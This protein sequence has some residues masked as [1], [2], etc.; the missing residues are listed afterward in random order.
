MGFYWQQAG[1]TYLQYANIGARALRQVL[2]QEAR[3]QAVKREEQF[4]KMA[5]WS[6]GKQ[7]EN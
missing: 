6:E 3:I 7:G 2:K 1:L 5:K 4:L